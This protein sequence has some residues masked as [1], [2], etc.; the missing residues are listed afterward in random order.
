[1]MTMAVMPII[2][3]LNSQTSKSVSVGLHEFVCKS[4]GI[5]IIICRCGY[6]CRL[7]IYVVSSTSAGDQI[8]SPSTATIRT[9]YAVASREMG[10]GRP[11]VHSSDYCGRF[12]GVSSACQ[13]LYGRQWWVGGS[14]LQI[15][16]PKLHHPHNPLCCLYLYPVSFS[17]YA[18]LIPRLSQYVDPMD[19]IHRNT[20][21]MSRYKDCFAVN[22]NWVVKELNLGQF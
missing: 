22:C 10:R 9:S 8:C 13:R 4:K 1:M 21:E 3:S 17:H 11:N 7:V 18:Q 19:Q 14:A 15:H 2:N 16:W 5:L 20:N 12:V 6:H